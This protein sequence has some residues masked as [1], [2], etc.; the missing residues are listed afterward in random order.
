MTLYAFYVFDRHCQC[1]FHQRWSQIS[2]DASSDTT[3]GMGCLTGTVGMK[4]EEEAKLVF[5][6][7]FS[8]R[9]MVSKLTTD[10]SDGFLSYKTNTYKLH[11]F[12]SASHLRMVLLT[13]P[14]VDTVAA[15]DVL[16]TIYATDYLQHVV[17]N[18]LSSSEIPSDGFFSVSLSKTFSQ[19][20]FF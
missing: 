3:T 2:S 10:D 8:L 4:F 20:S 18:P 5:G 7:V 11:F 12:E 9:N 1:V 17:Q 14:S 13:D 19:C 15:R 16:K 6:V